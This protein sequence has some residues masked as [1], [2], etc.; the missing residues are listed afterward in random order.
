LLRSLCPSILYK[1]EPP[2]FVEAIDRISAARSV[3]AP[4]EFFLHQLEMYER[5]GCDV[6]PAIHPEYRR[7]LMA[8]SHADIMDGEGADELY[9]AYYPSPSVSPRRT[10]TTD[11]FNLRMTPRTP[12]SRGNSFG[13]AMSPPVESE[14]TTTTTTNASTSTAAESAGLHRR[15][16]KGGAERVSEKLKKMSMTEA[17]PSSQGENVI[18]LGR[19]SVVVRGRRIRCKMCRCASRAPTWRLTST[20]LRD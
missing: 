15:L 8:F 4:T 1:P 18:K 16:S 5:C 17:A 7:F 11:P 9:L 20:I 13:E 10:S 6:N 3:V 14:T 19:G 12:A 2:A